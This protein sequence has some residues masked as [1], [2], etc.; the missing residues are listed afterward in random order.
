MTM[1]NFEFGPP[2]DP[3]LYVPFALSLERY[4]DLAGSFSKDVKHVFTSKN[5]CLCQGTSYLGQHNITKS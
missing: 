2:H 3:K 5:V 1:P 4:Q